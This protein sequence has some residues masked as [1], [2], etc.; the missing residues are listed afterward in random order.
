MS[1][2]SKK[3]YQTAKILYMWPLIPSSFPPLKQSHIHLMHDHRIFRH[4]MTSSLT[5]G[6]K[7][8]QTLGYKRNWSIPQCDLI[9]CLILQTIQKNS[10][11]LKLK[12]T[13]KT[14]VNGYKYPKN[15]PGQMT[16]PYQKTE[17]FPVIWYLNVIP[18]EHIFIN[19]WQKARKW[20]KLLGVIQTCFKFQ[21]FLTDLIPGFNTSKFP[22]KLATIKKVSFRLSSSFPQI[23]NYPC[24]ALTCSSLLIPLSTHC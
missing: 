9:Q 10:L 4:C 7:Y 5:W 16:T 15:W 23:E 22:K 3:N 13:H 20:L 2:S 17:L 1:T 18:H 12:K 14:I 6:Q 24:V 21:I 8:C 19:T 11:R